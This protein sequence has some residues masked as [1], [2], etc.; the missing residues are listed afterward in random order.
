ADA[1]QDGL[2]LPPGALEGLLAPRVPI[3]RVVGM[4]AQVWAGFVDQ[5]VGVLPSIAHRSTSL[6]CGPMRTLPNR[7]STCTSAWVPSSPPP[8]AST[9]ASSWCTRLVPGKGKFICPAASKASRRS[10]CCKR[11]SEERRV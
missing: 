8:Y 1:E 9:L 3:H 10:F 5:P 11:R 7:S 6:E 4:L 2:V